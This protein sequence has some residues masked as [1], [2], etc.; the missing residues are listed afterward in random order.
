LLGYAEEV[1]AM[2]VELDPEIAHLIELRVNQGRYESANDVVREAMHLLEERERLQ[3]LRAALAEA[4]AEID[5]GEYVEW[6]S[7]LLNVLSD[8]ADEMDAQ[9]LKP[10][11]DVVP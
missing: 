8:E 3:S 9:G 5:R 1:G 6:T 2:H 11:S 4:E 10:H 7:T